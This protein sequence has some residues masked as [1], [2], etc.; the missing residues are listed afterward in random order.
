MKKT[1]FLFC[2]LL[3]STGIYAEDF[4]VKPGATGMGTSWDDAAD[5]AEALSWAENGDCIYVA[6]GSYQ[7]SFKCSMAVTVYGNC[8]G[9]EEEPPSYS[10]AEGLETFLVGVG[11]G[12]RVLYLDKEPSM[13]YGFDISGGNAS[14]ETTG[15]GRGGGVYVN[16]GGAT[17]SYC[18]IHNNSGIDG[19]YQIAKANGNPVIGVGGG[20]YI[21]HGNLINCIIEDNIATINPWMAE[22]KVWST[23]VGGGIVLDATEGNDCTPETATMQGCIIRHNST[24]PEDDTNSYPSQGGGA[25]VKS[26]TVVSC[27]VVEN[28]IYGSKNN[29]NVG[30]GLACTE[31]H[32]DIINCT[33]VGNTNKGLGGGLGFQTTNASGVNAS[34]SNVIAWYNTSRDDSYGE[35]NANVRY[36]SSVDTALEGKISI[37]AISVPEA[38]VSP[39]AITAEPMFVD[40]L[41]GDYHLQAGSPCIDAGDEPPVASYAFDLD[42]NARIYGDAPDLGCY[43]STGSTGINSEYITNDQLV[44]ESYY[45]P[46]GIRISEPVSGQICIVRK[47]FKSGKVSVEKHLN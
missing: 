7:G 34:V 36:G 8:E 38:T 1:Y 31:R 17:L 13:W 25:A 30:G 32:A 35:G 29:Q 14:N 19:T 3:L 45:T 22:S 12:K 16:N 37:G 33:F 39:N 28:H 42:G 4:F 10:N 21:L 26:G 2:M 27:L 20:A 43:E 44:S 47:V 9:T 5:F 23:G 46:A 40:I 11:G 15:Q 24:T 41:A 6:K 18:R